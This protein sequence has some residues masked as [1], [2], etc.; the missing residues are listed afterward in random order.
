MLSSLLGTRLIYVTHKDPDLETDTWYTTHVK[1]VR[2]PY[3]QPQTPQART[4]VSD[5]DD[6]DDADES[7]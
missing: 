7:S 2:A 1:Q 4:A 3:H 5:D 6:G